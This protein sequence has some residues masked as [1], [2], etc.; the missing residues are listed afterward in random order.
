MTFAHPFLLLG[1]L[2]ALIPLLVHLFDRRRP[3]PQPFGAIAFVLKSQKRT[4]SRLKLKRLLLYTLRT[5]ILLAIPIALARPELTRD[6][7]ISSAMGPKATVVVIDTSLSM[8]WHGGKDTLFERA[9]REAKSAVKGLLAEEPATVVTCGHDVAPPPPLS[10]ERGHLISLLDDLQVG[11]G[12]ADV[13]RCL[14]VA[15]RALEESPL[16]GKRII[17]VSDFT[18]AALR[19]ETPLPT[20]QGLK[21]ERIRPDVLLRDAADGEDALPNRA[22][23]DVKTEPAP[24]VDPRAFS[25]TFTARNFSDDAQRDVELQ[26]KVDGQVVAKGFIDLAARGTSQKTLTWR[27][28]KPGA[29]VV[30]GALAP[31]ELPDDDVRSTVLTVPRRLSALIVN[32]SPSPQRFRDE[33]FFTEAALTAPG[34]AV[35]AVVRDTD[36]AWREDLKQYDVVML[37]NVEAPRTDIAAQLTAFVQ[38]GGGLFVS[39]GDRIDADAWNQ[40]FGALLPRR[41]RLLKTSVEPGSSDANARAAR[42]SQVSTEHPLLSPFTGRAREGLMSARFLRYMLL[43][44]ETPGATEPSQ[45]LATLDD[46]AP[47]LAAVRRGRGRVLLFTSTMDRDWSD[48]A[49]RTSFLPFM[50]RAVAWLGGGLDEHEELKSRVGERLTLSPPPGVKTVTL[51]GPG[52]LLL[53]ARPQQDGSFLTDPVPAPGAWLAHDGANEV[54]PSLSFAATL[55]A[56]ESDLTRLKPD[57]LKV[58]FGEEAVKGSSGNSES[59]TPVWTWLIAIAVAAFFFEGMLLRK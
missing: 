3:R 28:D 43:D 22:L 55:D 4:A 40:A 2:G 18:A 37:L 45:V 35:R 53:D 32:G 21:G 13:T 7:T 5:L 41:L 16:Q 48:F 30:E 46:G 27:F 49:I 31:D 10:F 39:M 58:A 23:V 57:E 11:Y 17:V 42:L 12:S 59:K 47:A 6:G 56:A 36:S 44:A 51:K 1:C 19:L 26:L 54:V 15:A 25:F 34:A 24:Q 14:E 8:R 52:S 50:Q 38:Q 33:A 20:V 29:V 9:R